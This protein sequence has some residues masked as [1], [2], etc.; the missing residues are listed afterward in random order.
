MHS[1]RE[2]PA[3]FIIMNNFLILLLLYIS[4]QKWVPRQMQKVRTDILN[5]SIIQNAYQFLHIIQ[6]IRSLFSK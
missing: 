4:S 1:G 3:Q 5:M 2:V 6:V